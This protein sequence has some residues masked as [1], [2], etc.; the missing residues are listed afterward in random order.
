MSSYSR[1]ATIPVL[2]MM[3]FIP[4]FVGAGE[5]NVGYFGNTAIKGYDPVA[6]FKEQKSIKC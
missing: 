1:K 6:Y 2:I 5:V 4:G 3:I